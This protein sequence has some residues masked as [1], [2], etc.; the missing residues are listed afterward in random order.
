MIRR[1]ESVRPLI[2]RADYYQLQ[3]AQADCQLAILEVLEELARKLDA[4][5]ARDGV[6]P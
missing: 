1:S 5:I 4:Y 2:E 6:Q 3:R